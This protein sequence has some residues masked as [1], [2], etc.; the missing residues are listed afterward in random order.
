MSEFV[1]VSYRGSAVM[2]GIRRTTLSSQNGVRLSGLPSFSVPHRSQALTVKLKKD[3]DCSHRHTC[4]EFAL[5][6]KR[7]LL[8]SD[9]TNIN[10][11]VR[12]VKNFL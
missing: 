4:R 11:L 8:L 9:I 10:K 3:Y 1:C 7:Q 6:N 12:Q 2:F 5:A